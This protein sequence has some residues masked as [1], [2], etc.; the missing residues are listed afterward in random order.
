MKLFLLLGL[1]LNQL[2]KTKKFFMLKPLENLILKMIGLKCFSLFY[3][4]MMKMPQ[5]QMQ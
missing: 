3:L 2:M 5:I 1:M 4:K